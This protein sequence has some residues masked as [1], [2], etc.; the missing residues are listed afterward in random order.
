MTVGPEEG[1]GVK[2]EEVSGHVALVTSFDREDCPDSV[3]SLSFLIESWCDWDPCSC[4]ILSFI[5][6]KLGFKKSDSL[7]RDFGESNEEDAA[8]LLKE[9]KSDPGDESD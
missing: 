1:R 4:V 9:E 2:E 5:D 6:S 3:V 8:E 7:V